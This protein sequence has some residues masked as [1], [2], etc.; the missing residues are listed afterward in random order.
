MNVKTVCRAAVLGGCSLTLAALAPQKNV[1][2]T[3]IV[4]D[5]A[6][7]IAPG[8]QIQSDG[9]GFYRNSSN[10]VSQI[11]AIGDWELDARNPRNSTRRIYLEFS[12][13]IAGSAPGGGDPVAVPSGEYKF[14]AIAK[15]GLYGS[16]MFTL[17]PGA[18][19]P[20][21]LHVGFD[22]NGTK[23]AIQMDPYT[24]ANGPLPETNFANV[25]CIFPT[26]GTAPCSQWKFT[27]SG[28]YIA[29]DSTVKYRNVGKLLQYTTQ[30]QTVAQDHGD[31][32]FSFSILVT[33]P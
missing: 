26:S 28:T 8:L 21:P 11:Q 6:A 20:C 33:K 30:G 24:S 1:P 14:R 29:P 2:V 15:C 3:S 16:N 31:F 23:Y 27:P 32:Y 5:Y 17:A 13:P 10:L 12:K 19:M 25:T 4:L 18:T 9:E 7:D 22:Y